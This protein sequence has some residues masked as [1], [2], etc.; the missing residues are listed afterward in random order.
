MITFN[1]CANSRNHSRFSKLCSSISEVLSLSFPPH[2]T[3]AGEQCK[4]LFLQPNFSQFQSH[5]SAV[6]EQLFFYCRSCNYNLLC[7]TWLSHIGG[8]EPSY[9]VLFLE[10][11]ISKRFDIRIIKILCVLQSYNYELLHVTFY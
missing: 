11:K 7:V 4:P 2:T 10:S 1:F 6:T 8:S 5:S 9:A 3:P